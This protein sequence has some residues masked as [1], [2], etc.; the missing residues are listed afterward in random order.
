MYETIKKFGE[1]Y[2]DKCIHRQIRQLVNNMCSTMTMEEAALSKFKNHSN[3]IK[4]MLINVN[5]NMC[6]CLIIDDVLFS[7]PIVSPEIRNASEKVAMATQAL[8]LQI[9]LQK[10]QLNE[11]E[12]LKS[13]IEAKNKNDLLQKEHD[14]KIASINNRIKNATNIVE[15]DNIAQLLLLPK[16][17]ELE[18][19][20][21]ISNNAKIISASDPMM[22]FNS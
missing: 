8:N 7:Q 6:T 16:W 12:H 5:Q 9:I 14:E 20:K 3:V 15:R 4:E 1:N 2:D 18:K 21:S 10:S 19:F 22:I 13:M 11:M 17:F